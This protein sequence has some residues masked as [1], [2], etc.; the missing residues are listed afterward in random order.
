MHRIALRST[1]QQAALFSPYPDVP[2]EALPAFLGNTGK[3]LTPPPI[4][5]AWVIGKFLPFKAKIEYFR[6]ADLAFKERFNLL[7]V[8]RDVLPNAST[9]HCFYSLTKKKNN[10][11]IVVSK[12][13]KRAGF[14]NLQTCGSVWA[15]P[16]CS[17]KIAERRRMEVLHAMGSYKARTAGQVLL[18]TRTL[19][20]AFTDRL[21]VVMDRLKRAEHLYK[22][23]APYQRIR[24]RYGIVGTIRNVELT[25]GENGFHPHIHELVFLAD[26]V[27][28]VQLKADLLTRWVSACL[29]A[30]LEAPSEAHGLDVRSGENASSYV[31]KMGRDDAPAVR[32]WTGADEVTKSHTKKAKGDS[33]SPFDLLRIADQSDDHD[34]VQF[35]RARFAEFAAAFKGKRQLVVSPGL[36]GYFEEEQQSDED[37]AASSDTDEV[38]FATL[39]KEGFYAVRRAKKAADVLLLARTMDLP[40]LVAFVMALAPHLR[41]ED[42]FLSNEHATYRPKRTFTFGEEAQDAFKR[43]GEEPGTAPP[44]A[45]A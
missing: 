24:D 33:L 14:Q 45:I 11:P 5:R 40:A 44:A 26:G 34:I 28:Q 29:R 43:G 18:I 2:N 1:P 8:A 39:T 37:V 3:A 25:F 9:A 41:R 15:C 27:D 12:K 35:A 19:P 22:Q 36:K 31:T 23:G 20:H 7:S 6:G 32:Q 4:N 21:D 16:V 30:G 13:Y 10:V 17:A 42:L 38:H